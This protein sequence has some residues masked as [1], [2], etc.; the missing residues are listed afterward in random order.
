METDKEAFRNAIM[1]EYE[2]NPEKVKQLAL[3]VLDLGQAE[4]DGQRHAYDSITSLMAERRQT[5]DSMEKHMA[6]LKQAYDSMVTEH[7]AS[8]R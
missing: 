8:V 3:H 7:M 1:K 6:E 2:T 5:Y 4:L